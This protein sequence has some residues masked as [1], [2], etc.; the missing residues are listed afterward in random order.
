MTS[1]IGRLSSTQ[2]RERLR[3]DLKARGFVFNYPASVNVIVA[4]I[5]LRENHPT[6]IEALMGSPMQWWVP[7]WVPDVLYWA[8]DHLHAPE[9]AVKCWMRAAKDSPSHRNA[10]VALAR[11]DVRDI[12]IVLAVFS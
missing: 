5:G 9:D 7:S 10:L 3:A 4:D 8:L 1:K 12:E 11:A 6:D 2:A